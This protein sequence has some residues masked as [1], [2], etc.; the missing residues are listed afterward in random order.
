MSSL[1]SVACVVVAI[2][3][4]VDD[5]VEFDDDE[6]FLWIILHISVLTCITSGTGSNTVPPTPTQNAIT[7]LVIKPHKAP[8]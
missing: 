7:A 2:V 1:E 6:Q 5:M 3:D 4:I 8:C